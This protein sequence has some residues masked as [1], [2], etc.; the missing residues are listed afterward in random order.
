[1]SSRRSQA[2]APGLSLPVH[3]MRWNWALQSFPPGR[4]GIDIQA[5][6][7][8]NSRIIIGITDCSHHVGIG[9]HRSPGSNAKKTK[10]RI[11]SIKTPIRTNIQPGNIIPDRPDAV[12]RQS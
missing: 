1:M 12:L 3:H 4:H 5:D 9:F 10:L 11:N 2:G 7:G 6:I 8:E